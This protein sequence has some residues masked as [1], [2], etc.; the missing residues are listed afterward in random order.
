MISAKRY[1][2]NC[3]LCQFSFN[4]VPV[5]RI[6]ESEYYLIIKLSQNDF[7]LIYKYHGRLPR[8][9]ERDI[10]EIRNTFIKRCNVEDL[11]KWH[12]DMKMDQTT[13][14]WHVFFRKK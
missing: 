14:H 12:V 4:K 6:F 2:D 7:M 13:S 9:G 5:E 11:A 3:E 10:Q 1:K 8:L